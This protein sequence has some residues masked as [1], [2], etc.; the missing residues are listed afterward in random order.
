MV[1]G[2]DT[3]GSRGVRRGSE[4]GDHAEGLWQHPGGTGKGGP[5][6]GCRGAHPAQ[7][8]VHPRDDPARPAPTA[9]L[10]TNLPHARW[11]LGSSAPKQAPRCRC[12]QGGAWGSSFHGLSPIVR[13]HPTHPRSG[14]C[15]GLWS[16]S[17]TLWVGKTQ[18]GG[19]AGCARS[20]SPSL[21]HKGSR[22][23]PPF[24]PSSPSP[25]SCSLRPPPSRLPDK[26][27]NV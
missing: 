8:P 25:P 9:P 18:S 12:A 13:I 26:S 22:R 10:P 1:R 16:P 14:T 17:V 11:G 6:C 15:W 27:P 23:F 19:S 2:G 5:A 20:L 21:S 4:R 7:P 3:E 24:P